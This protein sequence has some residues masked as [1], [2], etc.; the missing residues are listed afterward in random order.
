MKDINKWNITN[1]DNIDR[2]LLVKDKEYA[3]SKMCTSETIN[4]NNLHNKL[5]FANYTNNEQLKFII[6]IDS[7]KFINNIKLFA[8]ETEYSAEK[9][10][11]IKQ[12]FVN[13]FSPKARKGK[14]KNPSH[15]KKQV[16]L[17]KFPAILINQC[18]PDRINDFRKN[19]SEHGVYDSHDYE[20][21]YDQLTFNKN[22]VFI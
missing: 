9:E 10:F 20:A 13:F 18:I 15:P 1:Y 11:S 22:K 16:K 5:N 2:Y 19:N 8:N 3:F 14:K 7:E 12:A 17:I 6:K 4:V 21:C